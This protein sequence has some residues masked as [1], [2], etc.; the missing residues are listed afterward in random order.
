MRSRKIL[1]LLA[2]GALYLPLSAPAAQKKSP[3]V[4]S[5]LSSSL[6]ALASQVSP[7]VVQIFTTGYASLDWSYPGTGGASSAMCA[8]VVRRREPGS[9]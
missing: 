8:R 1:F 4:L 7:A 6:Q 2:L 3:P 9:R 5:E